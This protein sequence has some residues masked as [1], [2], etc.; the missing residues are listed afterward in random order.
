[1]FSMRLRV[2]MAAAASLFAAAC[3]GDT[4]KDFVLTAD[5]TES[6]VVFGLEPEGKHL[7]AE[8]SIA[9]YK[10]DPEKNLLI[11]EEPIVLG[12]MGNSLSFDAPLFAPAL[13]KPSE[14]QGDT[15]YRVGTFAP[16]TYA[17]AYA[18]IVGTSLSNNTTVLCLNK[19]TT[20]FDVKPGRA[21]YIGNFMLSEW[22][23]FRAASSKIEEADQ[24]LSTDYPNISV[25]LEQAATTNAK[26]K[27]EKTGKREKRCSGYGPGAR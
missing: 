19:G 26:F 18:R 25:P 24:A 3:A 13:R 15:E 20:V 16:G 2:A 11:E 8:Y 5:S 17:I 12:R 9:F 21:L 10:F 4:S 7:P 14:I 22:G 1:M 27:R 23:K 6:V